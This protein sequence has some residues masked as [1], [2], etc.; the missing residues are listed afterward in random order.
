MPSVIELAILDN[1]P[2]LLRTIL[3]NYDSSQP[4]EFQCANV[5]PANLNKNVFHI[6]AEY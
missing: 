6:I 2:Q 3:S 1:D 4:V 5:D